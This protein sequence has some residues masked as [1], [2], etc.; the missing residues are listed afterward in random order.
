[1]QRTARS[2]GVRS[3]HVQDGVDVARDVPGDHGGVVVVG[4]VRP[5]VELPHEVIWIGPLVD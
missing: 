3:Q 2:S 5:V 4:V 1:M